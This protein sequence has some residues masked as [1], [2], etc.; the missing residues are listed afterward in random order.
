MLAREF[1]NSQRATG[2]ALFLST[3]SGERS[4]PEPPMNQ[5]NPEAAAVGGADQLRQATQ[6]LVESS[7]RALR[8]TSQTIAALE[9][10]RADLRSRLES[11]SQALSSERDQRLVAEARLAA[12]LEESSTPPPVPDELLVQVNERQRELLQRL[13]AT[14]TPSRGPWPTVLAA[15]AGSV[16][17]A[18]LMLTILPLLG[19]GRQ[20]EKHRQTEN[21]LIPSSESARTTP[22]KPRDTLQ[23]RC[24]IPCWLEVREMKTGKVLFYKTLKGSTTLPIGAGLE[25]FSGRGDVMKIRINDGEE[26]PFSNRTVGKRTFMPTAR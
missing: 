16:L 20:T 11:V 1:G 19:I 21:Q 23:L 13:E 8:Q 10:E 5:A 17:G 12:R 25:V 3:F 6:E 4:C 22:A 14:A 2:S 7:N 9:A 15:F 26:A 18:V 24:E